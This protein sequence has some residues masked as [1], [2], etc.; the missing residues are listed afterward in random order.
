MASLTTYNLSDVV[1]GDTWEG[2]PEYHLSQAASDY[3]T[4]LAKVDMI[5]KGRSGLGAGYLFLSTATSDGSVSS[6]SLWKFIINPI[7]AFPLP[8]DTYDYSIVTTDNDS[9]ANVRTLLKGTLV[10]KDPITP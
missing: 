7:N 4:N 1:Q 2:I 5:I 3:S 6:A 8:K 9:P 10:V